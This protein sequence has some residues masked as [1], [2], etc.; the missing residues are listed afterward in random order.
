MRKPLTLQLQ[1][2]ERLLVLEQK[3]PAVLR[4]EATPA[5]AAEQLELAVACHNKRFYAGAACLYAAAFAAEPRLVDQV[6]SGHRYHAACCA[7]QAGCGRG[8]DASQLDE[9]ERARWRRQGQDWLRAELAR[10]AERLQ[11]DNPTN[12][13]KVRLSLQRWLTDPRLAGVRGAQAI[14]R[15]PAGEREGWEKLWAEAEALQKKLRERAK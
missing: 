6:G 10:H 15:L 4:G 3:L 12:R 9:K 5:D 11:R 13:R 8:K 1:Q 2:C 7:A 14:G